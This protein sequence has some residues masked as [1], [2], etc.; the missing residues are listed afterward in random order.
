MQNKLQKVY[1]KF[2]LFGPSDTGKTSFLQRLIKNEFNE[3][4][5]KITNR[6][7]DILFFLDDKKIYAVFYDDFN[8]KFKD[9]KDA[10]I[11]FYDI[12]NK[13]SFDLMDQLICRLRE[14]YTNPIIALIGMKMI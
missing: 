11:L 13:K 6:Q 3:N 12:T 1:K 9:N 8:E 14:L 2:L 4:K 10:Y 7:M 5:S